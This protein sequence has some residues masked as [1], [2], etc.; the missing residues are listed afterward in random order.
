MTS[1][2][3]GAIQNATTFAHEY[4]SKISYD[5]NTSSHPYWTKISSTIA[6]VAAS[7]L[8]S[9][10]AIYKLINFY[11]NY[12]V[13]TYNFDDC[14]IILQKYHL[15]LK[16]IK[17]DKNTNKELASDFLYLKPEERTYYYL[18]SYEVRQMPNG[19]FEAFKAKSEWSTFFKNFTVTLMSYSSNIVWKL[20]KKDTKEI[21][22]LSFD[23]IIPSNECC[24]Q[25]AAYINSLKK[26]SIKKSLTTLT[27]ELEIENI[28]LDPN[29]KIPITIAIK[30][31]N[32]SRSL[33][34]HNVKISDTKWI[35]TLIVK[36]ASKQ[37]DPDKKKHPEMTKSEYENHAQMLIEGIENGKYFLKK[38]HF[39]QTGVHLTNLGKKPFEFNYRSEIYMADRRNIEDMIIEIETEK[40]QTTQTSIL[41]RIAS[42]R[43]NI[44]KKLRFASC[45]DN[46][47]VNKFLFP[48]EKRH[49]C[50]TWIFEKYKKFLGIDLNSKLLSTIITF[51]RRF[52]KDTQ[53]YKINGP[54]FNS[55]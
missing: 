7:A 48:F 15:G 22:W 16:L 37:K 19:N 1:F 4:L 6:L 45:G 47:I 21:Y 41:Q 44:F 35:T 46:N 20:T 51:P 49:N 17:Y 27:R 40:N 32:I 23:Q 50:A 13:K 54:L 14:K 34:D 25:S 2:V 18:K 28:I 52:V 24:T 29:T 36:G 39:N 9:T 8:I 43:N 12:R 53:D 30:P 31:R 11:N 10:G 26:A 3:L 42:F 38:A 33:I 55:I 5:K